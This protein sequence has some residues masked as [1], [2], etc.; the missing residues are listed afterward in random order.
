MKKTAIYLLV[1]FG[2][3]FYWGCD[4]ADDG[5]NEPDPNPVPTL[6]AI[7][8]T[9][10]VSH[11]P[12]FTLTVTGT[13]FVSGSTIVF[14]RNEVVT[15]F[16]SATELTGRIEPEHS[17]SSETNLM[18]SI[19]PPDT[20]VPV[21][22][23]NP[24]PGGGDSNTMQFSLIP[25]FTFASVINITNHSSDYWGENPDIA[26][27]GDGRI[28]VVWDRTSWIYP[29]KSKIMFCRST[30]GGS[31]WSAPKSISLGSNGQYS[32]G[33]FPSIVVSQDGILYL[34]WSHIVKTGDDVQIYF[35]KS[36]DR[37][38]SWTT[39]KDIS[40]TSKYSSWPILAV[41]PGGRLAAVWREGTDLYKY[42]MFFSQS[43]NGGSS[44][45]SPE[46]VN[47]NGNGKNYNP[48]IAYD[49]D[50]NLLLSWR[51]WGGNNECYFQ[52][53]TDNGGSWSSPKNIT[54]NS[55]GS[56]FPIVGGISSGELAFLWY[57]G[58]TPNHNI[59]CK[60][61]DDDGSS[62]SS[63]T[64]ISS[65]N[66]YH[67][68]PAMS[69]DSAD[70]INVVWP[71]HTN[72]VPTGS[73]TYFSRSVDGGITWTSQLMIGNSG[74]STNGEPAIAADSSGQVYIVYEGRDDGPFDIFFTR[75]TN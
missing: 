55:S 9:E 31:S 41:S 56:Y 30:N 73:G 54:S 49:P 29:N 42:D 75:S 72:T 58:N 26:V 20:S 51:I 53:S 63:A 61:S 67:Q 59:Y 25:N 48:F 21:L 11:L 7:S 27:D 74:A 46:G 18:G 15:T 39:P 38:G 62:W 36:E 52:R 12:A 10:R 37:G 43:S 19:S 24:A 65:G 71:F 3:C 28:Y 17:V 64:K 68:E 1:V 34:I 6:S 4:P 2:M 14:N 33:Q 8:P 16:V 69:I 47:G 22:V 45:T 5:G 44:W 57:D 66:G 40:Q 60:R 50:G 35:S 23:R 70:N 32:G 13:G